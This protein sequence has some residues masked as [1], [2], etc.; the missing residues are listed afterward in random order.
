MQCFPREES[1]N[2]NT[3]DSCRGHSALHA[4]LLVLSL[5]TKNVGFFIFL[6][7]GKISSNLFIKGR[8]TVKNKSP[9]KSFNETKFTWKQRIYM[10]RKGLLRTRETTFC[11]KDLF[12]YKWSCLYDIVYTAKKNFTIVLKARLCPQRRR[13]KQKTIKEYLHEGI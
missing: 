7:T 5:N 1:F 3:F 9:I 12:C 8:P 6:H 11:I 10:R 4:L 13:E 2:Q